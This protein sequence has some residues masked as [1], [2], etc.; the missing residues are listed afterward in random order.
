MTQQI[1]AADEE[2]LQPNKLWGVLARYPNW[3]D[4]FVG[5]VAGHLCAA[6]LPT[7]KRTY[8]MFHCINKDLGARI[9]EMTKEQAEPPLSRAMGNAKAQFLDNAVSH[10]SEVCVIIHYIHQ[11][12]IMRSKRE[13]IEMITHTLLDTLIYPLAYA[14]WLSR[15]SNSKR[16]G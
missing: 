3:Q 6:K 16:H 15:Y 13:Y 10:V 4:N 1:L 14:C 11:R 5:N 9:E 12:C 2:L 7:G 8:E